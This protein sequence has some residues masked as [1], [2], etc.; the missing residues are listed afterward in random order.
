[1]GSN[2]YIDITDPAQQAP[3]PQPGSVRNGGRGP[4]Q[5]LHDG[6][7]TPGEPRPSKTVGVGIGA[8]AGAMA[9][10]AAGILG[11]PAGVAAGAVA[12]AALGGGAG[13][14]SASDDADEPSSHDDG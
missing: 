1:M 4:G 8:A 13:V 9:G 10:A 5:E 7:E 3:L 12:G 11:G 6:E 14:A 2:K